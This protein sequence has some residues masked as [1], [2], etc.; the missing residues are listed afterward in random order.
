MH[1]VMCRLGEKN[2]FHRCGG[3]ALSIGKDRATVLI[4][5]SPV[6]L[7]TGLCARGYL[8]FRFKKRV[9]KDAQLCIIQ[10]DFVLAVCIAVYLEASFTS[11]VLNVTGILA[12]RN[13]CRSMYKIMGSDLQL[14]IRVRDLYATVYIREVLTTIG[15]IPVGDITFLGTGCFLLRNF[16]QAR[17]CAAC[18]LGRVQNSVIAFRIRCVSVRYILAESDQVTSIYSTVSVYVTS[19]LNYD[20]IVTL[21]IGCA[22]V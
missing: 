22:S 17:M 11:P 20:C 9:R 6:R 13:F 16:L 8:G 21:G 4:L 10:C 18:Q 14:G 1:E 19:V 15:A 5:T 3:L 2:V 7:V 12:S